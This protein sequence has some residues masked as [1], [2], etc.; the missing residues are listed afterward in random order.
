MQRLREFQIVKSFAI[1]FIMEGERPV[2]ESQVEEQKPEGKSVLWSSYLAPKGEK[3]CYICNLPGH[4]A[5]AC[6]SAPAG[7]NANP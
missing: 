1:Q 5:R 2:V 7:G 3:L 4:L 6:P